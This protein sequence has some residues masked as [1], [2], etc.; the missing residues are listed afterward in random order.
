MEKIK[1]NLPNFDYKNQNWIREDNV[2]ILGRANE[3][4]QQNLQY[5]EAGYNHNNSMYYRA[6]EVDDEI[7]NFCR[8][9]FPIYSVGIMKQ[10]VGQTLPS[11][12]DTFY[13]F[14]KNNDIDPYDCCRVNIFLED[15]R[16]GHYFEIN[17]DPIL[18]WNRG[19]AIIIERDEPHLSG[20]MGMTFK[21]TM[22]VTGVKN[23]LKRC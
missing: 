3:F 22:Q 5:I 15:W 13:Q 1:I 12:E 18:Q 6:F 20:N 9:L 4:E 11:H 16:S 2:T 21:Y 7:H 23:E 14:A 10:P 17:E 8:T 19:D